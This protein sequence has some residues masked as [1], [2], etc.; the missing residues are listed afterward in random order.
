LG[1]VPVSSDNARGGG[2]GV[3]PGEPFN[4]RESVGREMDHTMGN[5][6]MHMFHLLGHLGEASGSKARD[7]ENNAV[8][9]LSRENFYIP[10]KSTISRET[11][12]HLE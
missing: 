4:I 10:S 5:K 9:R 6:H 7:D 8:R 12:M 1:S 3:S 2:E 11:E